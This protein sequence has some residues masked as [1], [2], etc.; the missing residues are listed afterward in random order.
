LI[1]RSI[2]IR[3]KE[4]IMKSIIVGLMLIIPIAS[5]WA[6]TRIYDFEDESQFADWS[7]LDT[8]DGLPY[9]VQWQVEDGE[10]VSTSEDICGWAQVLSVGDDTWQDYVFE[11]QFRIE[12]TFSPSCFATRGRAIV[13]FAYWHQ[14]P[15]ETESA[16]IWMVWF[17]PH[18]YSNLWRNMW[19]A[20]GPSNYIMLGPSTTDLPLEEK[21][22]YTAR[23]ENQGN[24]YQMFVD[25]ELLAE[26]E[27]GLPGDAYGVT[28]F[29]TRNCEAHF[30]NIVIEGES[31]PDMATSI[32]PKAKLT[33]IWGK[34]KN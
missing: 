23:I 22:W 28:G 15:G 30:D 16:E 26:L 1:F 7:K 10:L 9:T 20:G 19:G 34:I 24:L 29:G 11:V 3:K 32:S 14:L 2:F 27:T 25:N 21:R 8:V 12:Q 33:T 6:G 17:G 18:N 4:K 5:V 31:I 13:L